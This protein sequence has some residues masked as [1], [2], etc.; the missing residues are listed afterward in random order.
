MQPKV[1]MMD[2]PTSA[3][4]PE[5]VAEVLDVTAELARQ[6]I[7]MLIVTHEMGFAYEVADRLHFLHEGKIVEE[8]NARQVL[9]APSTSVLQSFLR[10]FHYSMTLF[11]D[12]E[13]AIPRGSAK[14]EPSLP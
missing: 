6:G 11:A 10:R 3:L 14:K 5:L 4:D 12:S 8:G 13:A 1:L 9:R 2:E 7:T